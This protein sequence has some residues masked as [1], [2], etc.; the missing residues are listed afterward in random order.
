M[1]GQNPSNV[2]LQHIKSFLIQ[3]EVPEQQFLQACEI[4]SRQWRSSLV[5]LLISAVQYLNSLHHKNCSQ[6]S[7]SI[8]ASLHNGATARVSGAGGGGMKRRWNGFLNRRRAKNR[9]GGFSV[10][11]QELCSAWRGDRK[12]CAHTWAPNKAAVNGAQ[13]ETPFQLLL[14]IKFWD[15]QTGLGTGRM[16]LAGHA[17]GEQSDRLMI[18][19]IGWCVLSGG[20]DRKD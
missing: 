10:L 3:E 20:F 18:M 16:V 17:D 13:Q 11:H 19:I 14:L 7:T 1:V 9:G 15:S 12:L 4:S 5:F 8:W 2:V 6:W